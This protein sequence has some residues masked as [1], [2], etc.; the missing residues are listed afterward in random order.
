MLPMA[1]QMATLLK[2]IPF[3]RR[4]TS[5]NIHLGYLI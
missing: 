5:R 1:M 4:S 3:S 2:N